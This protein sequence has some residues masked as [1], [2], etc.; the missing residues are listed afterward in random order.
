MKL[1]FIAAVAAL[2]LSFQQATAQI[3]VGRFLGSWQTVRV[4][5][6]DGTYSCQ[7]VQCSGQCGL[8]K[9]FLLIALPGKSY[10]IPSFNNEFFVPPGT[11]ATLK[12]SG[13]KYRLR[14]RAKKP[15]KVLTPVDGRTLV[16]I[17]NAIKALERKSKRA[18]FEVTTPNGTTE[19]FSVRG[20]R[21]VL[22][23]FNEQCESAKRGY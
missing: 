16:A 20:F 5:L 22:A 9:Y 3:A 23:E 11:E 19:S 17:V 15:D 4:A 18:R 14:N 6:D 13:K 21:R 2:S 7:A 8:G 1:G 10:V 12:I